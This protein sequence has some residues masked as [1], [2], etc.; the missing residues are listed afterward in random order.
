MRDFL[1]GAEILVV[2][3]GALVLGGIVAGHVAEAYPWFADL[4]GWRVMTQR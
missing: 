3:F 1:G 4:I 2:I